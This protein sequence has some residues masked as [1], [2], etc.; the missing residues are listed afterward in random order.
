MSPIPA[1]RHGNATTQTGVSHL[2]AVFDNNGTIEQEVYFLTKATE[3][4]V[5][6]MSTLR[7]HREA[8]AEV[9]RLADKQRRILG[10]HRNEN[11]KDIHPY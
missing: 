8:K 1:I 3:T 11:I 10:F 6:K 7:D 4:F 5:Q 2:P 9:D